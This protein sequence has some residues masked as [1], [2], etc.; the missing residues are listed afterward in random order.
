M[1]VL[2]DDFYK[3]YFE[4]DKSLNIIQWK[5]KS[6]MLRVESFK[7]QILQCMEVIEKYRPKRVLIDTR[8]FQY[9]IVPDVQD[10]FDEVVFAAYPKYGVEK[11]AFLTSSDFFTQISL[12]QHAEP[13]PE[14][15]IKVEFFDDMDRAIAWLT[16]NYES[17]QKP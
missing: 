14:K 16:D 6:K 4:E 10:W 5:S 15:A 3:L 2:E 12:E 17:A 9:T 1:L 13:L 11:K 7:K 8:D